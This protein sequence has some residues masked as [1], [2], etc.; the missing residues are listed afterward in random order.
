MPCTARLIARATAPRP[1][2]GTTIPLAR[3]VAL[4]VVAASLPDLDFVV[5]WLS[6]V[7]YL[8]H[9]RG[10]T[11]SFLMLPLWSLL[12]AW[13]CAKLWRDGP[14]WRAYFSVFAWGSAS[15]SPATGSPRWH[16]AAGAGLRSALRAVDDLHHRPVAARHSAC[17]RHRLP[18]MARLAHACSPRAGAKAGYVA[19]QGMQHEKAIAFGERYASAEGM[20]GAT[21]RAIPRPASPYNWTVLVED[22][23]RVDYAQVRF[24]AQPALLGRIGVPLFTQLAPRTSRPGTRNGCTSTASGRTPSCAMHSPARTRVFPL[25]RGAPGAVPDRPWQPLD[26]RMVRGSALR[27]AG[28]QRDAVSLRAVPGKGQPVVAVQARRRPTHPG[29]L[30]SRGALLVV[31]GESYAI[32]TRLFVAF[33]S[34]LPVRAPSSSMPLNDRKP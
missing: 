32:A 3:R 23:D 33:G 17:R 8:Y 18:R 16:D 30:I 25:V 31:H 12:L 24:D 21:V 11:H 26:L 27:H 9:H 34:R 6:P 29:A 4:G 28:A 20:Q 10:I 19:F 22:A 15:I 13:V 5:G 14:G 7:A 1:R 2:P